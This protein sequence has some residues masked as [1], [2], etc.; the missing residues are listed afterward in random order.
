MA[1]RSGPD[2]AVVLVTPDDYGTV[3]ATIDHLR[4]QTVKERLEVI[5][6]APAGRDVAADPA[7]EAEFWRLRIVEV[8]TLRSV[9]AGNAAGVRAAEAPL[10]AFGED[11]SFPAPDW[12]EALI[13]AHRGPWAA[14]G[15]AVATADPAGLVGWADFL[16]GYGPWRAPAVSG[17]VDHLPG[18]NSSYKRA[19]LLAYGAALES[20]LEAETVLHWDLRAKGH[21]LYLEGAATLAHL[22]F[23]R[24]SS[25]VP[26]QVYS[27]RLFAATR[28]QEWSPVR[29]LLYA[30]G[31]PL[32]PLVRLA[33][34][35]RS[36]RR[37]PRPPRGVLPV[38]LLGLILDGVGQ[39]LGYAFGVGDTRRRLAPFEHHRVRHARQRPAAS[40]AD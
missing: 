7:A 24:L 36:L 39:F 29:R 28:A 1:D 33:R 3:R 5:V 11:H 37:P 14:V 4:R 6:V 38:L 22:N 13:A 34:T 31:A 35:S 19:V 25:W 10:V 20:M 40:S 17:V 8:E 23:G 27:G 12:A 21:R 26:V 18:H 16:I 9:G 32:I 2:L 15:P 30:G